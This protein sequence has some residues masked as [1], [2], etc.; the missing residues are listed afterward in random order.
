MDKSLPD[1]VAQ[2][3]SA[4][5][6]LFILRPG[7]SGER[8]S[9]EVAAGASVG[10]LKELALDALGVNRGKFLRLICSGKMIAPNGD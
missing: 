1:R 5:I 4:L 9:V 3:P 2:D 7:S 8:V 10:K 6:C